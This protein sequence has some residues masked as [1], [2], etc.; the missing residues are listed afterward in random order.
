MNQ[1]QN[2]IQTST[3]KKQRKPLT[4]KQKIFLITVV[5]V[6]S[7]LIIAGI[8]VLVIWLTGK[9]NTS[10]YDM[11]SR[12]IQYEYYIDEGDTIGFKLKD[13]F[14]EDVPL[15]HF[16]KTEILSESSIVLED[17]LTLKVKEGASA[18]QNAI[19]N[20]SYRGVVVAVI[21]VRVVD[22]DEYIHTTQDLL[23]VSQDQDKTYIVRNDLDFSGV[24]G[25]ISRFIGSIHFN[26]NLIDGFNASN[27][28]LFKDLNG[29]TITGLDLTNVTGSTILTSFGNYGV[30]ADYA[31][32]SKMRYCT[33][34]GSINVSSNAELNDVSY[35]GGFVGYASAL[36]RKS[37]VDVEP[38][39]VHLVSFLELTVSGT[40]D[41]RIGGLIGGVRNASI[42][43]SFSHGKINFNVSENQVSSFK[44]LY[45]GGMIGA[46]SKEYDI[47]AQTEY[48]DESSGMY[49]YSD[50]NVNVQGGGAHNAINVGGVFGYLENH[51]IVNCTYGG[52]MQ[53]D[54]TRAILNAGGIIG[55]TNNETTLKMNVRGVIVKGEMKIYS[56]SS[57]FAGGLIGESEETQYSS[58][59]QSITPTI[60]TDKS[61]VQGTQVVSQSVANAK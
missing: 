45:L 60:N 16:T 59:E 38:A 33:I 13:N 6:I 47:V 41:F 61:K 27:G 34:S 1:E 26:H 12:K 58:V 44:N 19:Y 52:K 51:S 24:A 43:N 46:L 22:A 5:S 49:S 55:R 37:Y 42:N 53:V 3:N 21:N 17:D 56:L 50:I 39:Y 4:K 35:I 7:A 20:F 9:D 48:L 29:A 2:Q 54:L 40:G 11:P 23:Q 31:S 10:D 14:R 57:V 18:G 25:N 15:T 28:G 30:V 36:K 32:N 8:V